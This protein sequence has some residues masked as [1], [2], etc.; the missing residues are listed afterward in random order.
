LPLGGALMIIILV[1]QFGN[2]RKMV[3]VLSTIPLSIIGVILG[4]FTVNYPLSFFGMLGI[5]ALAG[6][7]VNNAILLIEQIDVELAQGVEPMQALINSGLRRA[8]PIFLTTV[9]TIAGLYTLAV[10]G[11]FWGPLAVA[12]MG[13]LIVSTF[14]TLVI[15]PTLYAILF[16]INYEKPQAVFAEPKPAENF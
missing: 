12:I 2:V 5:L 10:S 7:V 15:T 11:L 8:Y 13:G 3:I 6:I 16:G 1:L 9:T 14:L 4:L